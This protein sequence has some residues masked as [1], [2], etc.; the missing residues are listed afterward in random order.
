MRKIAKIMSP[1]KTFLRRGTDGKISCYGLTANR[2]YYIKE[3]K[4][5]SSYPSVAG[6][7]IRLK[8]DSTGNAKLLDNDE[9]VSLTSDGGN[10]KL[11]LHVMNKK[12]EKTSVEILKK[13]YNEDGSEVEGAVPKSVKVALYRS[14]T[15]NAGGG[16]GSRVP[17]NFTTQYFGSGNGSNTDTSPLSPGD[18]KFSTTVTSGGGIEFELDAR[19]TQEAKISE[20]ILLRQMAKP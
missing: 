3:T 6:K 1:P 11:Q 7:I 16:T 18:Y 5:P 20:F 9:L 15:P 14:K 4:S 10:Q 2:T 13:W 12:P 17:V 8:L 19:G